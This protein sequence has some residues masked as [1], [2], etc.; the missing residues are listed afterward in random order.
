MNEL[1]IYCISPHI[2]IYFHLISPDIN[3][4]FRQKTQQWKPGQS[5]TSRKS[6]VPPAMSFDPSDPMKCPMFFRGW[7]SDTCNQ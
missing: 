3:H 7:H 4:L 6:F 5:K 1:S 2:A